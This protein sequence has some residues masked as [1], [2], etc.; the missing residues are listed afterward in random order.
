MFVR[1]L[2][3]I[4]VGGNLPADRADVYPQ[5]FMERC[6]WKI[7]QQITADVCP[8]IAAERYS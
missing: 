1:R 8:Q 3:E 7:L 6:G 2:S 5:I 4:D